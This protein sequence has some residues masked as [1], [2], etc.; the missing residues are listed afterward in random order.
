MGN[1]SFGSKEQQQ[2]PERLRLLPAMLIRRAF[3]PHRNIGDNRVMVIGTAATSVMNTYLPTSENAYCQLLGCSHSV[4]SLHITDSKSGDD[5]HNRA[6]QRHV[7]ARG[8]AFV[9][10]YSVTKKETLEERKSF[11]ELIC[12]I[13]GNN[14]HKFPIVLVGNKSD[15]TYWEVALSDGA[16]CVLGWNCAFMEISAKADV[17]VQE[18][19]HMV[20]HYQNQPDPDLEEPQKKSQTPK[21][22]EKMLDKCMIM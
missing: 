8:H 11:Y 6:L 22:I 20:L 13:K 7:I 19:F 12:K 4:L 10:V 1:V 16:T 5:N 21:T 2:L 15:D 14:L 9:L 18:L 17:N 3:K